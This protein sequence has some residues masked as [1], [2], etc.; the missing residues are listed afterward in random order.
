MNYSVNK[1]TSSADCDALIELAG[2]EKDD[3][4]YRKTTIT[5][6][7][8]NFA[9]TAAEVEADLSSTNA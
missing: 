5:H 4:Q 8:S 3:L 2:K 6:Q 9:N 7:N 1:L